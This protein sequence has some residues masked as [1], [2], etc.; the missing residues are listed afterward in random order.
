M[1]PYEGKLVLVCDKIHFEC[2]DVSVESSW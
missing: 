1:Q 2:V